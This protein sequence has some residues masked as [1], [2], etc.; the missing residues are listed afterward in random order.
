MSHFTTTYHYPSI[1]NVTSNVT[2]NL[3]LLGG[4]APALSD[5]HHLVTNNL[6]LSKRCSAS[7]ARFYSEKLKFFKHFHAACIAP[8][9]L[10]VKRAPSPSP[11]PRCLNF[12]TSHLLN[13][14]FIVRNE[15]FHIG[16]RFSFMTYCAVEF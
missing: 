12:Y 1:C 8:V 10:S 9:L 11:R 6:L 16:M 5:K 3:S 14:W 15:L 13:L 2:S 7:R 4:T